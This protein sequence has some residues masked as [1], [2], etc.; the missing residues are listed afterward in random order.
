M[1]AQDVMTT[2]VATIRAERDGAGRRPSHGGPPRQRAPV[3][4][5]ERRARRVA[6]EAVGGVRKVEDH[7]AVVPLQ[8]AAPLGET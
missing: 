4:D 5:N 7:T 6:V 1:Q 3:V 8:V 2:E